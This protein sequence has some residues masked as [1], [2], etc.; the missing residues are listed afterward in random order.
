M[1]VRQRLSILSPQY[2][3]WF[4]F[5]HDLFRWALFLLVLKETYK[6]I[7][8]AM[9]LLVVQGKNIKV[10]YDWKYSNVKGW[11]TQTRQGNCSVGAC[12]NRWFLN[13]K[14]TFL[15]DWLRISSF[16]AQVR[17]R[18][19]VVIIYLRVYS[20]NTTKMSCNGTL[21]FSSKFF[22]VKVWQGL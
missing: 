15:K 10:T 3:P 5:Y 11:I 4:S 21:N 19:F 2:D 12:T 6:T 13:N 8:N 7:G 20:R 1:N 14:N 22:I 16:I 9:F 18:G 17:K